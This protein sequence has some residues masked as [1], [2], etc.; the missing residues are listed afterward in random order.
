MPLPDLPD[1]TEEHLLLSGTNSKPSHNSET[2]AYNNKPEIISYSEAM[3]AAASNDKLDIRPRIYDKI[4]KQ[5]LLLDTGSMCSVSR[6]RETDV[7]RPDLLLES[8][9]GSRLQCFGTKPLSLRLGRKEYHIKF[10][11][12]FIVK[13]HFPS[14]QNKLHIEK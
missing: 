10:N 12:F 9:D 3:I 13:Y 5:Y 11:K 4:T 1:I 14:P 6:P 2:P 7:L 8:A